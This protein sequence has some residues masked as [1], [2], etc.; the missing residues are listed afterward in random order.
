M[1]CRQFARSGETKE[2]VSN[3]DGD[4]NKNGKKAM[5]FDWHNN[6]F[7]RRSRYLYISL[8]SLHDSN[9]QLPIFMFCWGRKHKKEMSDPLFVHVFMTKSE[10]NTFTFCTNIFGQ[11]CYISILNYLVKETEQEESLAGVFWTFRFTNCDK[12]A[13]PKILIGQFLFAGD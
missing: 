6:N 13:P 12:P 8:P 7:A 10:I 5:G 1:L 4:G 11:F 3:D 9:V 2:S